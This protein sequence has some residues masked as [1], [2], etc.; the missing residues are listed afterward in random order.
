VKIYK[1]FSARIAGKLHDAGFRFIGTET[2]KRFPQYKVFLYED[3][4]AFRDELS[5]I[6]ENQRKENEQ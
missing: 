4:P 5:K 3:T 6:T 1:V 2:N